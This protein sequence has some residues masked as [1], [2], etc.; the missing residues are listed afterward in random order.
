M[1]NQLLGI[2]FYGLYLLAMVRPLIPMMEYY[3]NYDYIVTVLCE[4]K[5]RPYL[6]CKGSCYLKEQLKKTNPVDHEHQHMPL[7]N[8]DDYPL[9][10]VTLY[11]HQLSDVS[12]NFSPNYGHRPKSSQEVYFTAFRPPRS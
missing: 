6:E 1:K 3:A 4:N 9:S 8:L 7:I 10:P 5:D 2:F 11:N 12:T